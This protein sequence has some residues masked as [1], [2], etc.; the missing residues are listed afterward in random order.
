MES[1]EG[2]SQ[3]GKGSRLDTFE[4]HPKST[5]LYIYRFTYDEPKQRLGN[6]DEK[7]LN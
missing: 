1:S 4:L 7:Q 5:A 2:I 3:E 6:P